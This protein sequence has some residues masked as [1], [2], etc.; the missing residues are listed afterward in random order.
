MIFFAVI[1]LEKG[2]TESILYYIILN[3]SYSNR[4]SQTAQ[5]TFWNYEQ[6][7]RI[8]DIIDQYEKTI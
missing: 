4:T 5:L 6:V 2:Y 1:L 3:I 8:R 7:P